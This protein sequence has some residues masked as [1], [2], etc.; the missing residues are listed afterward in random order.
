VQDHPRNPQDLPPE[1]A[2]IAQLLR[3]QRHSATPL[4]LDRIKLQA[5][6]QAARPERGVLG[7]VARL[8]RRALTLAIAAGM[9]V[10]GSGAAVAMSGHFFKH[11]KT[12]SAAWFQ[13]KPPC[14][15]KGKDARSSRRA[16]AAWKHQQCKP[17]P[18][19]KPKPPPCSKFSR[20]HAAGVRG[21]CDPSGGNGSTTTTTTGQPETLAPTVTQQVPTGAPNV[22]PVQPTTHV[23][24][25]KHKKHHKAR[26]H[27]KHKK[28]KKHHGRH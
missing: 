18:H 3:E 9:V 6:S 10:A 22:Q 12:A 8:R 20:A 1:L 11:H 17:K 19:P 28:H 5:K 14:P 7:S 13:Y 21:G 27:R 4:E 2:E 26:H 25:K 23:V 24:H 15:P 16:R